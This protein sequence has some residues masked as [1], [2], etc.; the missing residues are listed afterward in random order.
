VQNNLYEQL[1]G[2]RE[3][4]DLDVSMSTL[5]TLWMSTKEIPEL[6]YARRLNNL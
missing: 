2:G 3:G 6:L 5:I 4:T 1:V